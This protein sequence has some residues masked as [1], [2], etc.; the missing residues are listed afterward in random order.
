M[1]V[2]PEF[3]RLRQDDSEFTASIGYIAPVSKVNE[4]KSF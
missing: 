1:P 2:I 3:R 4:L